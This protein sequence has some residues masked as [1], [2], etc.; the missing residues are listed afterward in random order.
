[1]AHLS[2][3]T[4]HKVMSAMLSISLDGE[5]LEANLPPEIAATLPR[6][7]SRP[8]AEHLLLFLSHLNHFSPLENE[9][10]PLRTVLKNAEILAKLRVEAEVFRIALTELDRAPGGHAD[11]SDVQRRDLYTRRVKRFYAS[12]GYDVTPLPD[13]DP[14]QTFYAWRGVGI[15]SVIAVAVG[16]IDEVIAAVRRTVQQLQPNEPLVEGCVVLPCD[17]REHTARVWSADL[18]PIDYGELQPMGFREIEKLVL[19]QHARFIA[20]HEAELPDDDTADE[21]LEDRLRRDLRDDTARLL[22]IPVRHARAARRALERVVYACSN[23][24]SIKPD[25]P[26]PLVLPLS[27]QSPAR[28]TDL[29]GDVFRV[30][31]VPYSPIALPRLLEEGALLPIFDAT[32]TRSC[33][34]PWL[35]LLSQA[36]IGRTKSVLI[37]P[38]RAELH[39]RDIARR[40]RTAPASVRLLADTCFEIG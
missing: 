31:D 17:Q 30:H 10:P 8:R 9:A 6:A 27:E 34:A 11:A 24:F 15:L 5:L 29:I 4:L 3:D 25:A 33:S 18:R 37:L 36:L 35:E 21:T 19:Q 16:S 20:E 32:I 26:A 2:T 14:S 39:P 1:M 22:V 12:C 23:D 13:A 7:S 38:Q 28:L 40:L